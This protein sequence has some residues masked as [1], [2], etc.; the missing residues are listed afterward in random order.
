MIKPQPQPGKHW[1]HGWIV[2]PEKMD[3]PSGYCPYGIPGDRLWVRETVRAEELESGLDGVRYCAD[4]EFIPIENSKDA[5]NRWLDL[6]YYDHKRRGRGGSVPS[7]HMPR[8]AS[9]LT[10]EIEDIRV[11]RVQDISAVDA[12]WEG[13]ENAHRSTNRVTIEVLD[14]DSWTGQSA[15][16]EFAELWDS[17]NAKPRRSKTNPYTG[18]CDDCYV[19]Y[20][21]E[22]IRE[23]RKKGALPWYVVGNPWV[24]VVEFGVLRKLRR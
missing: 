9:R 8:W 21:W 24:W 11:E 3:I 20:P 22:D 4:D 1:K 15:I 6:Y 16:Q 14:E 7:I 12:M 23:T 2:D 10:P 5:S 18:E 19:S 13:I 17:I